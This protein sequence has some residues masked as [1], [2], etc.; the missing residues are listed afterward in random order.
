MAEPKS[1]TLWVVSNRVDDRVVL[2]ERDPQH[3]GG[4]AF[5]GGSAP[6]EVGRTGEVERL[7]HAGLLLE[8]PEPQDGPKKPLPAA[9]VQPA[10]AAA[11][12]GQVTRLGRALD[13]DLFPQSAIAQAEKQQE[14]LPDELPVPAGAV[15]PPL[16][17][18]EREARRR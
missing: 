7:L 3:P 4:E 9:A 18:P 16:P 12:P 15:V 8:V 10:E 13:P 2:W 1:E 11:A 17:A 5:V 14:K 6:A